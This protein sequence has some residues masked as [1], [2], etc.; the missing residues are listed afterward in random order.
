MLSNIDSQT[1]AVVNVNTFDDLAGLELT[2]SATDFEGETTTDR[3]ARRRR[4]WIPR[5][6]IRTGSD[7]IPE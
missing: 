5:V 4:N 3:L 1:F 7:Y 2:R 6:T